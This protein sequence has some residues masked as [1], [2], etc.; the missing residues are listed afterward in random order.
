MTRRTSGRSSLIACSTLLS[1]KRAAARTTALS[2]TPGDVRSCWLPRSTR[3]HGGQRTARRRTSRFGSTLPAFRA[4]T[5]RQGARARGSAA[6]WTCPVQRPRSPAVTDTAAGVIDV[7]AFPD[8]L[9]PLSPVRSYRRYLPLERWRRDS[10]G[11]ANDGDDARVPTNGAIA[12]TSPTVTTTSPRT[13][14]STE[15][16]VLGPGGLACV[17]VVALATRADANAPPPRARPCLS[18][19]RTRAVASSDPGHRERR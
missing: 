10:P 4:L 6:Q 12:L 1:P 17:A 13:S 19:P 11:V 7:R 8:K 9:K 18:A 14:T 15:T 16:R 5:D 3:S 2:H